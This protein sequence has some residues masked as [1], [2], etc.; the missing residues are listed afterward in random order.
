MA[1]RWRPSAGRIIVELFY[2]ERPWIERSE[3]GI[4]IGIS[5]FARFVNLRPVRLLDALTWLHGVG[6]IEQLNVG[7]YTA[8]LTIRQ[9]IGITPQT[10]HGWTS[11]P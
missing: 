10:T 1:D 11:A 5:R 7:R 4:T 2:G 9:P 6:I 8:T 3:A